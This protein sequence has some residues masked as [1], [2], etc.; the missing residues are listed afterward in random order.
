MANNIFSE[1]ELHFKFPESWIVYKYDN[2]RFYRYLSG[3]GLKGVDFIAIHQDQLFLIEVKNYAIRFIHKDYDP[4][5]ALLADPSAYI[6]KYF[7]KFDDTLRLID[8]IDRY[9]KRKWWYRKLFQPFKSYFSETRIIKNET[10]FWS[11]AIEIMQKKQGVNLVLWLEL[12]P[13]YPPL[14]SEKLNVYFKQNIQLKIP[15]GMQF[16][17]ANSKVSFEGILARIE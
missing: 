1:S 2:H 10:G 13:G 6:D 15:D 5:D 12:P 16:I 14:E 8:V 9:Y 4:M 11:K 17:V 7:R 3:S